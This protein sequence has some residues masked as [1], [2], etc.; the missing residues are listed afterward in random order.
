[1]QQNIIGAKL[2]I[3]GHWKTQRFCPS[4]AALVGRIYSN[5]FLKKLILTLTRVRSDDTLYK[6]V[7]I[8]IINKIVYFSVA[9]LL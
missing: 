2:T 8:K 6:A 9:W 4:L 1:M 3:I 7:R 5:T